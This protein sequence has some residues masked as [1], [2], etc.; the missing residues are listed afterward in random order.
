MQMHAQVMHTQVSLEKVQNQ[1]FSYYKFF[2]IQINFLKDTNQTH[3]LVIP[4]PTSHQSF[5]QQKKKQKKK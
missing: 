1:S 5:S 4:K 3:D 2:F